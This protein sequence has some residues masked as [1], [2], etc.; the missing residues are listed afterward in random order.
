[1][2]ALGSFPI[3]FDKAVVNRGCELA[4][5]M[6]V[7]FIVRIAGASSPAV[8]L[9]A[10]EQ[11]GIN[12]NPIFDGMVASRAFLLILG[13][14]LIDCVLLM[15]VL[16]NGGEHVAVVVVARVGGLGELVHAGVVPVII[17]LNNDG[18]YLFML[19][20]INSRVHK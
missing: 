11:S 8:L 14:V 5:R 19:N 1:M 9:G 2:L 17:K 7:V 13:P 4:M 6:P 20:Y 18:I 3:F 12:F 10:E 16:G 15:S